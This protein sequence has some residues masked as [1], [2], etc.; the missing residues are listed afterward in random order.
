MLHGFASPVQKTDSFLQPAIFDPINIRLPAF[1]QIAENSG[2]VYL[3]RRTLINA[4]CLSPFL[5]FLTPARRIE[6]AVRKIIPR[7]KELN[8]SIIASSEK[9]WSPGEARTN[10]AS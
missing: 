8:G 1:K 5:S 6:L 7:G 3:S 2:L 10:G 4:P 9:P